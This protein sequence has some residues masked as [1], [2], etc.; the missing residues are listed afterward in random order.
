M[1]FHRYRSCVPIRVMWLVVGMASLPSIAL[2]KVISIPKQ[3]EL[4][5]YQFV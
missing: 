3:R 5:Y 2:P 4:A 1:G